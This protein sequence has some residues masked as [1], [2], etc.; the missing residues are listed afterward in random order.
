MKQVREHDT[1]QTNIS[2][3][4]GKSGIIL[5]KHDAE[6]TDAV[7]RRHLQP[8][9]TTINQKIFVKI[10]L[11]KVWVPGY[12]RTSHFKPPVVNIPSFKPAQNK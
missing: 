9:N 3:Y 4:R 6:V 8:T 2:C 11:A 7:T 5:N 10:G 1:V 12:C